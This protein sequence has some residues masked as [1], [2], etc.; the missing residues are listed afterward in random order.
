MTRR[1]DNDLMECFI[2]N[3]AYDITDLVVLNQ[4]QKH[5]KVHS[6]ADILRCDGKTVDPEMFLPQQTEIIS[7]RQFSIEKPTEKARFLWR[8]ALYAIT[9][10]NL[11]IQDFRCV[12][13][14]SPH[15]QL[16]WFCSEDALE[17]YHERVGG[18]YELYKQPT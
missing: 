10:P 16:R 1:G 13:L 11:T 18:Y 15:R 3:G 8:Q 12:F 9:L 7:T 4:D 2:D 6:L 17:I 5:K 14:C